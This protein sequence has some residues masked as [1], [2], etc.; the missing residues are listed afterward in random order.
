MTVAKTEGIGIKIAQ[1]RVDFRCGWNMIYR[2][3]KL[4]GELFADPELPYG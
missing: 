3:E 4:N 1:P 2:R